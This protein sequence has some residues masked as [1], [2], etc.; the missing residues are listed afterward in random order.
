VGGELVQK[1]AVKLR[2]SELLSGLARE[3]VALVK[4]ARNSVAHAKK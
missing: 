1:E 2:N 3:F 4:Q